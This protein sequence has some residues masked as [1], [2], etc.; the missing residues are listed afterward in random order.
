MSEIAAR[1]TLTERT[2]SIGQDVLAGR[3]RGLRSSLT[4]AGPTCLISTRAM[5]R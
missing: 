5:S 4:F 1:M 2:I 3:R